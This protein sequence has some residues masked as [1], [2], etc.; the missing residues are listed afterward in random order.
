VEELGGANGLAVELT[1]VV[2]VALPAAEA[3]AWV[4]LED[5][6]DTTAAL[7]SMRGCDSLDGVRAAAA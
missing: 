4:A 6:D 5:G 3:G 2:G 7:P 1:V